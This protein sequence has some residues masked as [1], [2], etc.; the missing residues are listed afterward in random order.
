MYQGK[1]M[2]ELIKEWKWA[3][4]IKKNFLSY[5]KKFGA[6]TGQYFYE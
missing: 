6:V 3:S 5:R 4:K 1:A 2:E